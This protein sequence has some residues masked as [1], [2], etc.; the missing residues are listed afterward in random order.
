MYQ[1]YK[2]NN[3]SSLN[4]VQIHTTEIDKNKEKQYKHLEYYVHKWKKT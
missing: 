2:Q 1:L 4:V 3:M